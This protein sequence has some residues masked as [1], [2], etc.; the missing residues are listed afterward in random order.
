[1]AHQEKDAKQVATKVFWL[2]MLGAIAY[3][4]TVAVFVLRD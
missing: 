4:A 1:M 3:I 2:T